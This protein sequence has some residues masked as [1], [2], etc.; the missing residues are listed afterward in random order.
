MKPINSDHVVDIPEFFKMLTK[1]VHRFGELGTFF[2]NLSGRFDDL[3]VKDLI[4]V[5]EIIHACAEDH[6]ILVHVYTNLT[7]LGY[8]FNDRLAILC[9]LEHFVCLLEFFQVFDL[10]EVVE[11]D[12]RFELLTAR[13]CL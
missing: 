13:D 1:G 8:Q 11:A 6:C 4:A 9:F 3:L 5:S 2:F 7:L 12:R 10:Q